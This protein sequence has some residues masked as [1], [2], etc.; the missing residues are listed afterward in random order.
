MLIIQK[1]QRDLD[2]INYFE[3]VWITG[4]DYP[5]F[6]ITEDLDGEHIGNVNPPK[7]RVNQRQELNN[8]VTIYQKI[9]GADTVCEAKELIE[10]YVNEAVT[11]YIAEYREF[12]R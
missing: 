3:E 5:S 2:K 1:S 10:A 6:T 7:Y 8:G 12:D 11:Q 4:E 9:F